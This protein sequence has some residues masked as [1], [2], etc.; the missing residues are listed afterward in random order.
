MRLKVEQVW[1]ESRYTQVRGED[2]LYD[3]HQGYG[4]VAQCVSACGKYRE[5]RMHDFIGSDDQFL[6]KLKAKVENTGDIHPMW[7]DVV[8][9]EPIDAVWNPDWASPEFAWRERNGLPL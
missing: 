4:L 1:I 8:G 2:G 7:W 3:A 5:I 6:M 9:S